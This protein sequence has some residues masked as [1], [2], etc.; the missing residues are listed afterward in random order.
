MLSIGLIVTLTVVGASPSAAKD[1]H[2]T[3]VSVALQ[4]KVD[5]VLRAN[6]AS[7]QLN[8]NQVELA[9]G[10]VVT[11]P[12]PG[13]NAARGPNEDITPPGIANCPWEEVCFYEHRDFE[14]ARLEFYY[15]GL[16]W[17]RWW[18]LEPGRS[19]AGIISSYH[20]NQSGQVWAKASELTWHGLEPLFETRNPWASAYV[21]DSA[22]DRADV[23]SS[24]E[25]SDM[26]GWAPY[27]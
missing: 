24:C 21:G 7:R 19:W 11:L 2:R 4:A 15:C 27:F 17:L 10:V 1:S 9:E 5:A 16:H 13:E 26:F 20:N 12:L 8:R 14:G 6:P 22:N 3:R 25:G 23:I 18:E